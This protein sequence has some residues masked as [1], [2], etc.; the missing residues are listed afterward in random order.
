[1][2]RKQRLFSILRLLNPFRLLSSAGRSLRNRLKLRNKSLDY[3]LLDLPAAMPALPEPR[4]WLQKRILG[5]APLSLWNFEKLL[6]KIAHDLRPKGIIL[7]F[8]EPA[9]S[10]ADLQTLRELFVGFRAKGKQIIA[11][12]QGYSLASYFLASACDQIILQPGGDLFTTGLRQQ[13]LFLKQTL[14]QLGVAADVIAITPFKS[15]LDSLAR[16]DISPEGRA[17]IEWLLDSRYD[18]LTEAI[19][20]GRAMT[21]DAVRAMIDNA[22]HLDESAKV[23]GYV[24]AVLHQEELTEH[25]RCEHL[26]PWKKARKM[27]ITQR[28]PRSSGGSVAILPVSGLMVTGESG[29]PPFD[30]PLPIPFIGSERAGDKTVIQQARA[31]LEADNVKA[32]VLMIDSG[33]GSAVAAE[34]MTRTL[35]ELAKAKPIVV[36]MNGVA[37]SGGYYIATVGQWIVA[38]PG[39]IT[40]S[41]GVILAKLVTQGLLDRLFIRTVEFQRG[42]N[43]NIFAE[44]TPF[45]DTQREK[46]R[47]SIEHVYTTFVAHVARAR[48]LSPEAVDAVGGGRVWTGKQALE[49]GLVDELGGLQTA[50]RKARQLADLPETAPVLLWQKPDEKLPPMRA[51][52]AAAFTYYHDGLK[53]IGSGKAQFLMDISIDF[54]G[55]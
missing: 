16:E 51:N 14:D 8:T 30:L 20:S 41:I 52:P 13:A 40:G 2:T 34:A 18:I 24:D 29:A 27:L 28:K 19:A 7:Q 47:A 54:A 26:V 4:G 50:L 43:A 39:T 46:M 9:M 31:L 11:Y 25:L 36:F 33:G 6:D 17:Q 1:M 10:L 21:A 48:H 23:Q 32:V 42:E 35:L 22:P 12:A 15:A 45:N 5:D 3:I 55:H 53:S 38:Q 44:T 37:A 49:H